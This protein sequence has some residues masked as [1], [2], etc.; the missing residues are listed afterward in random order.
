MQKLFF[1]N[2]IVNLHVSIL[3]SGANMNRMGMK[4]TLN[5]GI[6]T[7]GVT[8]ILF[9]FLDRLQSAK[10]FLAFSFIIRII[11]ACGNSAFLTGSFRSVHNFLN[12]QNV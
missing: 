4:F 10:S 9:G 7:V 2:K 5:F 1:I 3:I 8:S 11:E 12:F 6:G